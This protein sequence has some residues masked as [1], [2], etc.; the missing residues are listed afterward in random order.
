MKCPKLACY[1]WTVLIIFGGLCLADTFKNRQTSEV[2]HGYVETQTD[3]SNT[4]VRTMEKGRINLNLAAWDITAD[5]KGR[6]NKVFVITIDGP[7]MLEI[8]TKAFEQAIARITAE[9]PLFILLEIDTPGGDVY[10]TKKIC[11]AIDKAGD[12]PVI[13]FI[14]G[15]EYG[16]AISAGVAVSLACEKIYMA[17][18]TSIGA[19]TL[20]AVTSKGITDL[21]KV[22]GEDIAEKTSSS[23]QAYVASLAEKKGR[24]ALL[25]RAM[26]DRRIEVIEVAMADDGKAFV[27]PS[28]KTKEQK[29]IRKWSD[30]QSLLTLTAS[31]AVQC[32]V[33]DKLASSR[34]DVL[35]DMNAIDAQ[36]V[37]DTC[38]QK[39]KQEYKMA[40][41]RAK[42]IRNSLDLNIKQLHET[43]RLEVAMSMFRKITDDFKSLIV[44]A[45]NYPDLHLDVMKLENELNTVEASFRQLK[46]E[47]RRR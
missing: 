32:G 13:A 46:I 12:C 37:T 23:W 20:V 6:N 33:A 44:L 16:G 30:K 8:E 18:N 2:L 19:A 17:E 1:V 34:Q 35:K 39:A 24:S 25:A 45:K 26:I 21:K 11:A 41:A 14:K 42:Q 43:R 5:R 36:I 47:S 38:L 15:G 10:L 22:T 28:A 40:E 3:D 4:P 7:I 29:F 27:E 31:E 9:G